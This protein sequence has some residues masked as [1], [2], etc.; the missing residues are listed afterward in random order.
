M[1]L[2]VGRKIRLAGMRIGDGIIW[3]LASVA[4]II[5]SVWPE[6]IYA[7]CRWLGIVSP[8][9]LV[10]LIVIAFL[11]MLVFI[12]AIKISQLESRLDHLAQEVA[13]RDERFIDIETRDQRLL[14][15][16]D[17]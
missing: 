17:Q 1:F 3:L 11:L 4:F 16:E 10:Y 13:L 2:Y 14:E 8:T 7:V 6:I 5:I 12:N 9:N 15:Q